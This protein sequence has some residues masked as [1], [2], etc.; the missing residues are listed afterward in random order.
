LPFADHKDNH[1]G[2]MN[3]GQI[4]A[5]R[6]SLSIV[7]G[8]E[9]EPWAGLADKAAAALNAFVAG[10][11]FARRRTD[12]VAPAVPVPD[13]EEQSTQA[14]FGRIPL[15]LAKS[16]HP[17]AE[18]IVTTSPDITVFTASMPTPSSCHGRALSRTGGRGPRTER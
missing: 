8:A 5:L 14:A 16:A 2:L 18:R 3:P 6:E 12:L 13:G 1:A 4:A 7:E 11:A 9:W 17:R 10:S 15:D